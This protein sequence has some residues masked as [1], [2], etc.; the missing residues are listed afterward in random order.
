MLWYLL[1]IIVQSNSVRFWP[2]KW[3]YKS[4]TKHTRH[5]GIE[6]CFRVRTLALNV[7]LNHLKRFLQPSFKWS[8]STSIPV[9]WS[10]VLFR[11]TN[12]LSG[13]S[14]QSKLHSPTWTTM[15]ENSFCDQCANA[16][17]TWRVSGYTI[18]RKRRSISVWRQSLIQRPDTLRKLRWAWIEPRWWVV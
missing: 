18:I 12:I 5:P 15:S 14:H 2:V 10:I 7:H 13:N 1:V 11:L 9:S 4:L 6:I 16:M 17:E 3:L 8:I